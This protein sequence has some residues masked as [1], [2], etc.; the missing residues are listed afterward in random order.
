MT[1]AQQKR[2]PPPKVSVYLSNEA[3][4]QLMALAQRERRSMSEMAVILIED[5]LARFETAR[6]ATQ[7]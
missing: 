4:T 7:N 2:T 5:G 3:K 1:N 6:P